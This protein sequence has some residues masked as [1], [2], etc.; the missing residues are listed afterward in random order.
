[1]PFTTNGDKCRA[2]MSSLESKFMFLSY[3]HQTIQ[4]KQHSALWRLISLSE[5]QEPE[6]EHEYNG[7]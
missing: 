3:T 7:G 5:L 1:M 2:E 4:M 6:I